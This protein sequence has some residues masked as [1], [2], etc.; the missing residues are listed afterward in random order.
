MK[1]QLL[2]LSTILFIAGLWYLRT[3][4]NAAVKDSTPE[5]YIRDAVK[6]DHEKTK[7]PA[8]GYPPTERLM[9]VHKVIRRKL[10]AQKQN[11]NTGIETLKWKERGPYSVGGRTRAIMV[12]MNDPTM[13]T[14]WAAGV[15]GGLWKTTSITNNP[16]G[17]VPVNDN[18]DNI[19]ISALAQDPS[20]P[21][22]MYF[23]TGE[24]HVGDVSGI[25]I[26][27]T[28]DGGDNWE[29]LPSTFNTQFRTTVRLLVYNNGDVY[30]ATMNGLKRSKDK[31]DTWEDVLKFNISGGKNDITD[32]EIGADGT[33][34]AS[35]GHNSGNAKIWRSSPGSNVGNVGNWD[36]IA[37]GIATNH[38]RIELAA[39]PS[40]ENVLYAVATVGGT[41]TTFYVT[42]NKGDNWSAKPMPDA[43]F[44]NGQGWYDLSIVVDPNNHNRIVSGNFNHFISADGAN[45]WTLI[46]SNV[47]VDQ[48]HSYFEPGNSDVIYLGNDGGIYRSD[49]GGGNPAAISFYNRNERYN[50]TQFYACDLHPGLY[51]NFFLA[52][53]Q[54]NGSIRFNQVGIART[55]RALG[56]DGAYCHIDQNEPQF[57]IVS[58]Q[59]GNYAL[60][61]NEGRSFSAGGVSIGVGFINESDYDDDANILYA[62]GG[63]GRL[64][65]W[66]ITEQDGEFVNISGTGQ[67]YRALRVSPNVANRLY[68]GS[69]QG[70]LLMIDN[71]HTGT[72]VTGVSLGSGFPFANIS[73]IVI[74]KGN[75]DHLLLTFENYGTNSV[76]ETTDGGATWT[77]Q[78]GD[79]PDMPV[80][81]AIFNP[82]NTDQAFLAT[83]AGVWVTNDLD[84]ANTVWE[85]SPSAPFVRTDMLQS[86]ESD[87]LILAGTYG[88]GLFSC[89]GFSPPKA[90]ISPLEV[91]YLNANQYF[92]DFSVN[93]SSWS[94]DFGDGTTSNDQ[95]T[96]H[97]YSNIG[98]YDV[99]LTIDGGLSDSKSIKIL[100][101]RATPY[102]TE[103]ANYGGNFEGNPEDFGVHNISGS[104]FEKGNSTRP[105]KSGTN[106]GNN[107]W[108]IGL[109]DDF[110][111]HNTHAALYTPNY[112]LSAPGIYQFS[113]YAKYDI[114]QGFDGFRVEY[115]LDRGDSWSQLG[116][117]GDNW[118]NYSNVTAGAATVFPSGS[119]YFTGSTLGSQFKQ[120]KTTIQNLSGNDDVAFRFVFKSDNLTR[121]SGLAIDDV[122]VKAYKDD[123]ETKLISLT[124]SYLDF[125]DV[126]LNWVT[127][128]EYRCK[129]F[130]I[131]T[132]TN[133]RDFEKVDQ[134]SF[135][136]GAGFSI[137]EVGYLI[138]PDQAFK[139]DQHFFRIKVY[140]F[141]DNFFYSDILPLRRKADD[142]KGVYLTYPNPF[143]DQINITFNDNVNG[144]EVTVDLFDALGRQILHQEYAELND[145]KLDLA[146]PGL[147]PGV[148]FLKVLIGN[149]RYVQKLQRAN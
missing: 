132:S 24:P 138:E 22:N 142:P 74:E 36:E 79:L 76:W 81:D 139:L 41:A 134:P 124:G 93:P 57:Q 19:A 115:S 8:L 119:D 10:T 27:R 47:H 141:D 144:E 63:G 25:G 82:E 101:D 60:S 116:E 117:K 136:D 92:E 64:Y 147:A 80:R 148:Y 32:I 13:E 2:F 83:E 21:K 66:D 95:N 106:S 38:R 131:E 61:N 53:S 16:P 109:N 7:D 40:N 28:T 73:S 65:R 100:P 88:R 137:D 130:E 77:S 91:S 128:P 3:N 34:Y 59:F 123:L 97:S 5:Q 14:V 44:A 114:Q 62:Y 23:G 105:G 140:D 122:E 149:Q 50:V 111:E 99:K 55:T 20:N 85:P 84:G 89:D 33:L 121:Y 35:A 107:A 75:E 51:S 103:S 94:W 118:Y 68:V 146:V 112:D 15:T 45:T 120:Y 78:E 104:K 126:E 31:G 90:T 125:E 145:I 11:R 135:I 98:T 52:G 26:W 86:R 4:T 127:Q 69:S 143:N 54:D 12:D 87:K 17:W 133:G 72:N 108:V 9:E 70:S 58:S 18:F 29:F 71:A 56:G 67:G 1:K 49:N 113:F 43:G 30:A 129:G 6:E 102:D 48:H 42:N 110:Y 37:D 96:F 39:A 46:S